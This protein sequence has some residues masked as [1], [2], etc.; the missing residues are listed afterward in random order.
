MHTCTYFFFFS[1][2]VQAL[3]RFLRK[4]TCY[5]F[6]EGYIKNPYPPFPPAR[7]RPA[8][9][10]ALPHPRPLCCLATPAPQ[11]SS[12]TRWRRALSP[13]GSEPSRSPKL[14]GP[15]TGCSKGRSSRSRRSEGEAAIVT[16]MRVLSVHQNLRLCSRSGRSL[17]P[18][19]TCRLYVQRVF[20]G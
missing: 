7:A 15:G 10:R 19:G 6:Y 17:S 3:G 1:L 13:S 5:W 11:A 14:P 18:R 9:R 16:D 4:H 8:S 20:D 2:L 12:S